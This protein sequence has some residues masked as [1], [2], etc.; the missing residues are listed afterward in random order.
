MCNVYYRCIRES[1]CN[2]AAKTDVSTEILD[3]LRGK[4]LEMK[5]QLALVRP[6]GEIIT[7]SEPTST[8]LTS[9]FPYP[10]GTLLR[11]KIT[12]ISATGVPMATQ[13]PV[14]V[15]EEPLEEGLTSTADYSI[16]T[17]IE[18]GICVTLCLPL[19]SMPAQCS[20]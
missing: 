16:S 14:H 4:V 13:P 19:Y 17:C 12:F 8:H 7:I 6:L 20:Y 5:N 11:L 2:Y 10:I 15:K 1:H 9:M 3:I 18:R